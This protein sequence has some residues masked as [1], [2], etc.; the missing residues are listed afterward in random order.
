MILLKIPYT[1]NI[2]ILILITL[3]DNGCI[4]Y[5]NLTKSS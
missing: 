4:N 2:K 3:L 1:K 5:K